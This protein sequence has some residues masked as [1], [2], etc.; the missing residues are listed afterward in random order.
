MAKFNN[1]QVNNTSIYSIKYIQLPLNLTPNISRT[2]IYQIL[3]L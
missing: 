3:C 1:T 2:E